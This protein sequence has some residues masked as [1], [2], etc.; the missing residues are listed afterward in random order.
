MS[1]I[2]SDRC[3]VGIS[4]TPLVTVGIPTYNRPEELRRTLESITGQTYRNLEI[5]VSD[6]GSLGNAT[7]KI[8]ADYLAKDPRIRY[9]RQ[10]QNRGGAFNFDFVLQK[11][12]GEYFMWAA[13]DDWR[14]P[15]FIEVLL[16]ELSRNK[17]AVVAFC[18]FDSRDE[19]GRP[20]SGYPD[21]L[22]SLRVMSLS[23]KFLREIRF[24][25]LRE[26]TA[27]PH[28][29]YGLMRREILEGFSWSRFVSQFRGNSSDILFV[30]WLMGKGC[31]ALSERR[32]FGCTVG[33]RKDYE[34]NRIQ[35]DVSTYLK[36]IGEQISYIYSYA[37]IA[38]GFTRF[39]LIFL[40]P[41]K[42]L[43]IIYL[44]AVKPGIN[45][46]RR[47]FFPSA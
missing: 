11:R 20:V 27:K 33:N 8:V 1:C 2:D 26:G 47:R 16:K 36:F 24:F 13:D 7:E 18:D 41:W 32:L 31:L 45:Y 3:S 23:T 14:T 19:R 46:V 44:F 17:D 6:N 12:T 38:K 5:I 30:F 29:I 40:V 28:L 35:W 9:F 15:D 10:Q 34:K 39:V 21:F 43:E 42:V 22:E 25:L 37:R 4:V